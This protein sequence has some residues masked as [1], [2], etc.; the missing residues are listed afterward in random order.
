MKNRGEDLMAS[1]TYDA[2]S[3][4]WK[5]TCRVIFGRE[6]GELCEFDEWLNAYMITPHIEKSGVSG[7]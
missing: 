2:V 6:V 3:K 1:Q 5:S 7:N 4:A